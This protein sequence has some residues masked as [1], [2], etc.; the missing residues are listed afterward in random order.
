MQRCIRCVVRNGKCAS[1]GCRGN[2]TKKGN[3]HYAVTP[4][5][6]PSDCYPLNGNDEFMCQYRKQEYNKTNGLIHKI[7]YKITRIVSAADNFLVLMKVH[8]ENAGLCNRLHR[9][10]MHYLMVSVLCFS[11]VLIKYL[12]AACC[13]ASASP[14]QMHCMQSKSVVIS[15]A[16][17]LWS[18]QKMCVC[19]LKQGIDWEISTVNQCVLV[20]LFVYLFLVEVN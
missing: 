11:Q 13:V 7:M 4:S 10:S 17:T 15:T 20:C 19:V 8:P 18:V 5:V 12:H 2:T 1:C 9:V 16:S 6:L 3:A 14:L